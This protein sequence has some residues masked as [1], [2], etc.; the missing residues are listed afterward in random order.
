MT[1]RSARRLPRAG[2]RPSPPP[3]RRAWPPAGSRPRRTVS[4][5]PSTPTHPR[6]RDRDASAPSS[7]RRFT[8]PSAS[9]CGPRRQRGRRRSTWR[10]GPPASI[11]TSP[12][13]PRMWIGRWRPCA[14]S[15]WRLRSAPTCAS[16]TLWRPQPPTAPPCW[17]ATPILVIARPDELVVVDFKSDAP[18]TA[19]VSIT[20]AAYVQQVRSYA[21]LLGGP[22]PTRAALLF[23]ADGHLRWVSLPTT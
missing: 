19:D 13:R 8:S 9:C 3:P 5:R 6:P 11:T 4:G 15:A 17:R 14:V 12:T 2:V 1:A 18:P 20:H 21:R 10:H 22:L 23:T 16:S 7:A